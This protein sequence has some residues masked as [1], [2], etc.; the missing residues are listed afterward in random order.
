MKFYTHIA[1]WGNQLLVRA[2]ENGVRSNYKVKYEPTLYVPVQKETGWKTLEGNNVAPMKFLTIKEAKEFAEQYESQPHLV[3]GLTGFPY[4]YI[5]ETY[6]N[7][8]QFDSSQMRIVTIDIEVECENGF[9]N[10]DKALEPMLAIT[11][12]NHDTGRIK[13]WG[14][15]DYK[16]TREDVQYIQCQT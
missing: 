1:Q 13:V 12:K 6:P 7:Q 9:P 10:A 11:I 5:S 4:T 14:L 15:H 2:V 16:N 3:H 8:I